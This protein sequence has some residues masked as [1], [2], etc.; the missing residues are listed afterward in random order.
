MQLWSKNQHLWQEHL[1]VWRLV[2][3]DGGGGM[4][5]AAPSWL[6]PAAAATPSQV[7]PSQDLRTAACLSPSLRGCFHFTVSHVSKPQHAGVQLLQS[8]SV[9]YTCVFQRLADPN[10]GQTA[11]PAPS[12]P[13]AAGCRWTLPD[14]GGVDWKRAG[15]VPRAN[16]QNSALPLGAPRRSHVGLA[17]RGA[18]RHAQWQQW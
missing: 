16:C 2:K 3:G 12:P 15:G 8:C 17:G 14:C 13:P 5:A 4:R 1:N 18:P 6:Q 11:I 10:S 7:T 9:A